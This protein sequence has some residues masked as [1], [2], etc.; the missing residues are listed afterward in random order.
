MKSELISVA[1]SLLKKSNTHLENGTIHRLVN[2]HD[3]TESIKHI[4]INQNHLKNTDERLYTKLSDSLSAILVG[5]TIIFTKRYDIVTFP[6]DIVTHNEEEKRDLLKLNDLANVIRS[7]ATEE[8][9]NIY[10]ES[11]GGLAYYARIVNCQTAKRALID[12]I[13]LTSN[14]E[15][16]KINDEWS[17]PVRLFW[18]EDSKAIAS[19]SGPY[20][21]NKLDNKHCVTVLNPDNC[22]EYYLVKPS[23]SLQNEWDDTN[24]A[25]LF[26]NILNNNA[27]SF[28]LIDITAVIL[29]CDGLTG[30][31]IE[32]NEGNQSW[33]DLDNQNAR[34]F[35]KYAVLVSNLNSGEKKP[36]TVHCQLKETASSCTIEPLK[37]S[38]NETIAKLDS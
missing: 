6:A 25:C 38:I 34:I 18:E 3:F 16:F 23:L 10:Y 19:F 26:T 21:S 8:S 22:L 14:V 28:P 11:F 36:W 12:K 17:V 37:Q 4:R 7:F 15:N 29:D 31:L 32:K 35:I 27:D 33:E 9:L 1:E 24:S 13:R 30:L 5:L 20:S 2:D